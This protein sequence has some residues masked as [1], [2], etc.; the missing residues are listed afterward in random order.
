MGGGF[1][2][3]RRGWIG[4]AGGRA[5][6]IGRG[7]GNEFYRWMRRGNLALEKALAA[8]PWLWFLPLG[9]LVLP[10]WQAWFLSC[11]VPRSDH[12][13]VIVEPY[14]QAVQGGSLWDFFHSPGTDS[15]HDAPKLLHWAVIRGTGWDLRV[16]SLV[17]V[18]LG[19]WAAALTLMLWRRQPGPVVARW[20]A[21][22]LTC[23]CILSP[24]Q[25]MNWA[26]GIQICYTLLVASAVTMIWCLSGTKVMG[27]RW[28]GAAVAAVVA[29]F[30]FLNG[31]MVWGL[32]L[33]AVVVL[34]FTGGGG[35]KK[36]VSAALGWL[37]VGG[38]SGWIYLLGWPESKAV[39]EAGLV[40]KVM[41]AP[42]AV[43]SFF[44]KILGGAFSEVWLLEQRADRHELQAWSAPILSAM[45]LGLAVAAGVGCWRRRREIELGRVM[46]W[47]LMLLFGLGNAMAI[48]VARV[49]KVGFSPFQARYPS[50][51][52]WFWIGLLGLLM[53]GRGGWL[54]MAAWGCGLVMAW[55]GVIGGVQGWRDGLRDARGHGMLEAAVGLRHATVEPVL[56]DAVRSIGGEETVG[57]LDQ[58]DQ[59]GLLAVGRV[60]GNLVKEAR[61]GQPG[62]YLGAILDGTGMSGQVALSGWVLHA[63]TR[64]AARAVVVSYQPEGG[65]EKWLG[66]AT[67]WTKQPSKAKKY[68]AQV[69]EQRIGWSFE[70]LT[71][72]ETALMRDEPLKLRRPPLPSGPLVF[73]AYAFEPVGAEFFPLDGQL[74]LMVR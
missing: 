2:Q 46:P 17:C 34:G 74:S 25:W 37:V 58:L 12:W 43:A 11:E 70:P 41:E 32:G 55:G 38:I 71:G 39:G 27:W 4:V 73:R 57:L 72:R 3:R 59:M 5:L 44:G 45:G 64:R 68:E 13:N 31:W 1:L 67:R 60:P 47:A 10:W 52:V 51:T 33:G 69:F 35:M 15:R 16:E 29:V 54:R 14:L 40:E 22:W 9:F 26:W 7:V 65:E 24:I 6:G 50:F 63:E 19:G 49:G 42:G 66:V 56:M 18:A 36:G 28:W 53:L 8:G 23:F 48:T 62:V 61:V 20:A 30:S 21:G